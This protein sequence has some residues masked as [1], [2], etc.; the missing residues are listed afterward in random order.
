M[1]KTPIESY[2][3]ILAAGIA[4]LWLTL[5]AQADLAVA[6]QESAIRRG[7][8]ITPAPAQVRLDDGSASAAVRR[9]DYRRVIAKLRREIPQI[10]K[11]TQTVGLTIALVDGRRTVWSRGFGW[12]DREARRPV[13][14]D[15]L[16]QIGSASKTM[17]AAA[18][19]QLVE[20][21]L[22]DL[23]AP[24][25]DYVPE[26]QLRERFQGN[27][28]T[29]RSILTHHSGIP[30]DVFS[31]AEFG[32][33]PDRGM[34]DKVITQLNTMLPER[35]LRQ[36]WAYSNLGITVLQG[37]IEK[38]TGQSF[39]DYTNE[40]LFAPMGMTSTT[41]DDAVPSKSQLAQSYAVQPDE[42]GTVRVI[43]KPREYINIMPAGSVVSNAR[44]MAKY[45]KTMIAMGTAP[46]GERVLKEHTVRQ[47]ISPQ[48]A[49]P[50]D[51]TFFRMGLVW[52]VGYTEP[53]TEQ[54]V[55]HGGDTTF[56]HSM[57]AWLPQDRL[58]VYVTVNTAATGS[59]R[60]QVWKRALSL[61]LEAKTGR[62]LSTQAP[63]VALKAP[64]NLAEMASVAGIY[65]NNGGIVDVSVQG[66]A[67]AITAGA[68]SDGA[69]PQLVTRRTD[70]WY[71]SDEPGTKAF[72]PAVIEGDQVLL[73]RPPSVGSAMLYAQRI[74][75]DYA[76]PPE[77]VQRVGDYI[78]TGVSENVHPD[79][80]ESG[81]VKPLT[82]AKGV[83]L[84][85]DKVLIPDGAERAFTFGPTPAQVM[86]EAGWAIEAD[87]PRLTYAGLILTR[88]AGDP[89][90]DFMFPA[91]AD[92][93]GLDRVTAFTQAHRKLS[94][95]YAL[96]EWKR[97]D[98]DKIYRQHLPQIKLAAWANDP[99]AYFLALHEYLFEIDDGHLTIPKDSANAALIDGLIARQSGGGY[100][101]GLAELDGGTVVAAKVVDGGPAATAGIMAGAQILSW[102]AR[103]ILSAIG[104][105]KLGSLAAATHMSTSAH[106]RLEQ[107][108]LLTRAPVGATIIV[109]YR[110][111]GA[112]QSRTVQLR[113][114]NDNL[115]GLNL[116]DF[117]PLPSAEDE[118]DMIY[119]KTLDSGY[120]YI[121]LTALFEASDPNKY[122]YAILNKF[123]DA[124]AGFA[125]EG[126]RGLIIDIR[127]NHGGSDQLAADICGTFVITQKVY[128]TTEF[129]DKRTGRFIAFTLDT[130]TMD[131]VDAL[132]TT[133][134][135]NQF[136][137]PV[138]A[139]VNPRTLS[140]GEGPAR[141]IND[142]ANGAAVG[143][144]G[145]RGSFALAGGRIALPDGLSI[146][147][148]YG[149]SVDVHG[150][151][152]IDSKDGVGGIIPKVRVSMT[153]DNV[154]AYAQGE[155]V[156]LQY[157]IDYLK[158]MNAAAPRGAVS[159]FDGDQRTRMNRSGHIARR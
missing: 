47:M 91:P 26:L 1:I 74:P 116:L 30:Q 69:V 16:F 149:R 94:K 125:E 52:W 110:N 4:V 44:D 68:Q 73:M 33:Q 45:L 7:G 67:L 145:T 53:W 144:H 120:G 85:G 21:G 25:T 115:S 148:P 17:T 159:R 12:A 59:P 123:Q 153:L 78:V 63:S 43:R 18:I 24:I 40:H 27:K 139:L 102:G 60:D 112:R 2:P 9:V 23:D 127:G 3:R 142:L 137:R 158:K 46:T 156:E 42:N 122:P 51:Q 61:M 83:L 88:Q 147:Y 108:R 135:P 111:P 36:A 28:I 124:V 136:N 64:V 72:K 138:V 146:H 11:D 105:V 79:S 75:A 96:T 121:R 92:L 132:M 93:S 80:D 154:M 130:K 151:V 34:Y 39:I 100:G 128:E 133:P 10:M 71:A 150:V 82:V 65:A 13:T 143:F 126:V 104:A 101:L 84:L 155:D 131:I 87:G 29:V 58:G 141:C 55:N 49:S 81:E 86:R 19:M 107:A 89:R 22:V 66:E 95:E 106:Q 117:A 118:K 70:G 38:V 98:W 62:A 48:P 97:V 140:S 119:A 14:V 109:R 15:T 113:A 76:I 77:W 6:G 90:E 114:A 103:P 129:F 41:F 157:A 32:S 54:V 31:L 56:N 57:V 37:V 35:P 134:Q 5:L 152:Q 50:W 99:R 8:Q 20:Q